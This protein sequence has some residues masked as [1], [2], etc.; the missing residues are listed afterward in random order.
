[1]DSLL[2]IVAR[3]LITLIQALPLRVVARMGRAGGAL[4]Y[5]LD[6]RLTVESQPGSGSTFTLEL[7]RALE[8]KFRYEPDLPES[9]EADSYQA[10]ATA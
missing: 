5:L 2:Y 10:S 3:A 4:A 9:E 7:P 1:M 8:S 6:G